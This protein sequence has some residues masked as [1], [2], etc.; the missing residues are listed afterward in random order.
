MEQHVGLKTYYKNL[1][2]YVDQFD[3]VDPIW[4]EVTYNSLIPYWSSGPNILKRVTGL[5]NGLLEVQYGLMRHANYDLAFYFTQNTAVYAGRKLSRTPYVLCSDVSPKLMDDMALHYNHAQDENKM[6]NDYKHNT[7]MKIY[8]GAECFIT[9]SEWMAQSL[10]NDYQLP[11]E[12]VS[13]IPIGIDQ[14]IWKAE[15]RSIHLGPVKIL[16]VGGEFYRKGGQSLLDAFHKL[17]SG[18][19]ELHIITRTKIDQ[20]ESI[21]VYNDLEP[22]SP[23]LISKFQESDVFVFPTLADSFGIVAL[24]AMS[25]GLPV[26]ATNIGALPE[27]VKNGEHGYIIE[28]DDT[29]Q[30]HAALVKLIKN[31]EM[32]QQMGKN[33]VERVSKMFNAERNARRVIELCKEIIQGKKPAGTKQIETA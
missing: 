20:Q 19:A 7:N 12:N 18:S 16:F 5:A 33:G 25:T 31:P 4:I 1:R 27:I 3:D 22:N 26:I 15:N 17:D 30:L 8:Q 32:R 9:W 23:E 29:D 2:K 11:E 21:F 6:V 10:Y 13:V 28:P 24:E 14:T